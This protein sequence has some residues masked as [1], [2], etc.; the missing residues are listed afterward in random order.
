MKYYTESISPTLAEMLK[1]KGMPMKECLNIISSNSFSDDGGI[2]FYYLPTFGACFDWLMSNG[3][4]VSIV[5]RWGF[6]MKVVLDYMPVIN[7]TSLPFIK[8]W[9]EAAEA[10]IEKALTLI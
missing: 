8:D 5:P 2:H 1:E 7:G 3:V 6:V 4:T 10:A 9:H